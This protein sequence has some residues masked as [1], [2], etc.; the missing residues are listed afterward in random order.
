MN[1]GNGSILARESRRPLSRRPRAL[2]KDSPCGTEKRSVE[3]IGDFEVK[4]NGSFPRYEGL[5]YAALRV[6]ELNHG[7]DD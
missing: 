4:A 3:E 5:V 1:R 6:W 2:R 7:F